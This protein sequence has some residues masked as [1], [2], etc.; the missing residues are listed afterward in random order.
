MTHGLG[1]GKPGPR[2]AKPITPPYVENNY[3]IEV[4]I[5]FMLIAYLVLLCEFFWEFSIFH[6]CRPLVDIYWHPLL[7]WEELSINI[8]KN[9][10][11]K[12][13][14]K[15]FAEKR[16]SLVQEH[17]KGNKPQAATKTKRMPF[18]KQEN[19]PTPIQLRFKE[20]CGGFYPY[21]SVSKQ[22]SPGNLHLTLHLHY[23]FHSTIENFSA[24]CNTS[25]AASQ[26]DRLRSAHSLA[27]IVHC[28]WTFAASRSRGTRACW[29][30]K[31]APEQDKQKAS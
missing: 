12:N 23:T 25:L 20:L 1:P 19:S 4:K 18:L 21:T 30:A 22:K 13:S 14:R 29:R 24:C 3:R 15:V 11:F 10:E 17:G 9:N 6:F 7:K 28:N 16:K 2:A 27:I 5:T 8:H 26:V 31:V